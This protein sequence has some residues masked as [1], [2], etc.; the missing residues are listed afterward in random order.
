M[1]EHDASGLVALAER[2]V[3]RLAADETLGQLADA[4]RTAATAGEPILTTGCG[5]SEHAT[6]VELCARMDVHGLTPPEAHVRAARAAFGARPGLLVMIRPRGGD[7][8]AGMQLLEQ[9]V[10]AWANVQYPAAREVD[11]DLRGR[12]VAEA[13]FFRSRSFHDDRPMLVCVFS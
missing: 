9:D 5:T 11:G 4:I 2:L 8:S 12:R 10:A 1:S 3:R 6:R 13:H 7:F